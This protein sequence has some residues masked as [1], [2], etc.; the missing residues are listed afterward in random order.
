MTSLR[1][2]AILAAL[3]ACTTL[4]AGAGAAAPRVS[5]VSD[6][7]LTSVTWGNAPAQ[8][9]LEQNLDVQLDAG[10]CRR[11]NVQSCEFNG[12]YVPTTLDVLNG[13]RTSLGPVVVIVDGYND[14]PASFAPDVELTL[15]T[16]RNDGVQRV[17]WLNL[18]AVR[19]EYVQ[20]NAV[21]AAAALH[22]PELGVLDWNAYS[23]SHP[24]WYQTDSI[25][26]VPAGG[27]AIAAFIHQAI[28]D[29]LAPPVATPQPKLPA[30]VVNVKHTWVGRVG[31]RFDRRLRASGGVGT[32]RWLATGRGLRQA[33]LHLLSG[34]V[35]RG[36][37]TRPG[38]HWLRLEVV[39]SKGA[40]AHLTVRFTVR[41]R[42]H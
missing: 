41:P 14:I 42:R 1:R 36:R 26:L 40:T 38:T 32:L 6:S 21:L 19:P 17:L 28:L 5:I 7:V 8:A 29:A 3:L 15:D 4:P 35:L 2:F 11:L 20:K 22:H 24:E 27:V 10:V 31:T 37:P 16:L 34:G 23:S 9:A 39:D 12:G 33:K 30:L 25:H 18:H 13:W